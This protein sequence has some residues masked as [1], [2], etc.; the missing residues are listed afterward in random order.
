MKLIIKDSS[1]GGQGS[2]ALTDIKK[3]EVVTVLTGKRYSAKEIDRLI[4]EGKDII[5]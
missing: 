3:G 5:L 1:L 2:F 4:A